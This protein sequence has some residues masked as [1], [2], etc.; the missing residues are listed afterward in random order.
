MPS[1]SAISK[2]QSDPKLKEA[3]VWATI[4]VPDVDEPVKLKLRS[5]ASN[6]VRMWAKKRIREHRNYY[7]NGNNPPV[8]IEDQDEVDQL[9][10]VMVMDWNVTN[11]DGSPAPCEPEAVRALMTIWP[12]VRRDA[13]AEAAKHA[14]YRHTEE[15]ALAKNF[16]APSSTHS[17][18]VA[19]EA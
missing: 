16:A 17:V 18:T 8:E 14:N 19:K 5:I 6:A 12:D 7:L 1:I 9:A 2:G 10:D 3:G 11:D 15:V 4:I 13:L